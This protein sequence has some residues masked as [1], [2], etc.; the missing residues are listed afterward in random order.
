[1]KKQ[2]KQLNEI[3]KNLNKEHYY[4]N[5][6]AFYENGMFYIKQ[7]EDVKIESRSAETIEIQLM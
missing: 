6:R 2:I 4:Y 7:G 1:M 3:L 5:C